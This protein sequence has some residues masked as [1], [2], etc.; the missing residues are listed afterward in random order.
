MNHHLLHVLD[1][2]SALYETVALYHT[3]V[4]PMMKGQKHADNVIYYCNF[5][6]IVCICWFEML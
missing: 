4:C 3:I 6:Q 1:L 2:I 5:K